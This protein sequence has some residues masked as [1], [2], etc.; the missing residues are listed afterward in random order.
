MSDPLT[1]INYAPTRNFVQKLHHSEFQ[2]SSHRV[3][4][5]MINLLL[6]TLAIKAIPSLT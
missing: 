2:W 4:Y 5:K 3:P 6:K 1:T